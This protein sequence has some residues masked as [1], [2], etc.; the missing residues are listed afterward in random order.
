MLEE[1]T[2]SIIN[3][4]RSRIVTKENVEQVNY[5]ISSINIITPVVLFYSD[6]CFLYLTVR[7]VR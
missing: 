5:N 4:L 7:I 6:N 2:V 3:T 1:S